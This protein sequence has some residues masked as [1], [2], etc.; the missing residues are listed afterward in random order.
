MGRKNKYVNEYLKK[1]DD[2]LDEMKKQSPNN[3]CHHCGNWMLEYD[4][5]EHI[6]YCC[7]CDQYDTYWILNKKANNIQE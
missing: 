7:D 1:I 2:M 4:E 5:E 3:V 6:V